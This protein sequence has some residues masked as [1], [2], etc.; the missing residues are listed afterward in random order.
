MTALARALHETQVDVN[1]ANAHPLFTAL[2][3]C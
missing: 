2:K 1:G 3:V